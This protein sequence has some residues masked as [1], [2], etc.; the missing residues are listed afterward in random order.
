MIY[1]AL[2]MTAYVATIGAFNLGRWWPCVS[3]FSVRVQGE[4]EIVEHRRPCR[5]IPRF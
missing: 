4:H 1:A 3:K 5:L 2:G